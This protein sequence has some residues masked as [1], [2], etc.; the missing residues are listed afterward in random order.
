V[1]RGGAPAE[2]EPWWYHHG[3]ASNSTSKS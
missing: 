3:S 2:G 1:K